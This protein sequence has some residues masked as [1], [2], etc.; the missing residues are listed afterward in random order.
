M[1]RLHDFTAQR[2]GGGDE[3]LSDYD[4]KVVLIVNVASKCGNTPQYEGLQTLYDTYRERGFV[5]LGFP[6]N[7]FKKQE[8]G[9]DEEIAEFCSTNYGVDFPMFGKIDV[10]G[11]GAHP[12]YRWLRV[13]APGSNGRDIEWNFAKFL[14]NKD[15]TPVQR[16]GDKFPPSEIASDIE[17]LL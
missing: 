4:G 10:N 11:P 12:L 7:Q 6:C 3:A 9:T 15:G 1:P 8:P 14:I 2:L 17:K 5:V 16:Y 13:A